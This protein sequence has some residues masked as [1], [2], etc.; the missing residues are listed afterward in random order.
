[1][2]TLLLVITAAALCSC[3]TTFTVGLDPLGQ[4]SV[5]GSFPTKKAPEPDSAK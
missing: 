5:S 2:K 4:V 1:M 3:G